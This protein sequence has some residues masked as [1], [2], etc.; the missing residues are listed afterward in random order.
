MGYGGL[1]MIGLIDYHHLDYFGT[2]L[3]LYLNRY[4]L[5][6]QLDN[7]APVNYQFY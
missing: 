3:V 5:L 1:G 7:I 4:N 2:G 6:N